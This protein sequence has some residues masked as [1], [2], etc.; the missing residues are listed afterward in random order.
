MDEFSINLNSIPEKSK[1]RRISGLICLLSGLATII[2]MLI[3]EEHLPVSMYL[4]CIYLIPEGIIFYLDGLGVS[5]NSLYGE[6]HIRID[7]SEIRIKKT[8]FSKVR[9]NAF[10]SGI[11]LTE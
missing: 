3:I 9:K 11:R 6:A 2:L 10:Y 1:G 5:I 7:G 8:I 4:M